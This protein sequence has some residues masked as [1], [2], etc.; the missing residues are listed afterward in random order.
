M[1]SDKLKII[2]KVIL[3][4]IPFGLKWL[5]QKPLAVQHGWSYKA[6]PTAHNVV[7]IGSSFAGIELVKR[8]AE[9]LP[10]GYRIILI[11]KN[12]HLNFSWVFPRF[13]VI[14]GYERQAFIPYDGITRKAPAGIFTRLK[15]IVIDITANQ[16]H[17]A[18]GEMI[19]YTYLA[20]ATGSSQP[21]PAKI[22]STN[23]NEGSEE[24]R[25]VQ[26]KI[27]AVN[28]IAII[29][30][31]AMGVE[32][33]TDIKSFFP[34]KEVTLFHSRYQLLPSFGRKLHDFVLPA[35]EKL[36]IQVILEARPEILLGHKSLR[37]AGVV[38]EFDLIVSSLFEYC[39]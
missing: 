21:L 18:S 17:L 35:M 31:G 7:V 25:N 37:L 29:G 3:L 10:T 24:L 15:D 9:T 22:L 36:G 14:S 2:G 30:G 1:P 20:I 8:L 26:E 28:R 39:L 23:L 16:V 38:Q 6:L 13:S 5:R 32:I 12:S 11:E 33:A 4:L 27:Q 19:D 34:S